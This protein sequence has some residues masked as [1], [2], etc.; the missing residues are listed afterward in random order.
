MKRLMGTL[1]VV[2]LVAATA[3]VATARDHFNPTDRQHPGRTFYLWRHAPQTVLVQP[4][5]ATGADVVRSFSYEPG[6]E[7]AA[8][9]SAACCCQTNCGCNVATAPATASGN[10]VRSFSYEPGTAPA[11]VAAPTMT[12]R[13][14]NRGAERLWRKQHS[15]AR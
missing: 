6:S 14:V 10:T 13:F 1:L 7:A 3:G 11:A 4:V 9:T 12:H 8:P 15:V 5:P 2:A